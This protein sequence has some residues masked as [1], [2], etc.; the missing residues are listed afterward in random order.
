ML[1]LVVAAIV[2]T[3][4]CG[5]GRSMTA[6]TRREMSRLYIVMAADQL[7]PAAAFEFLTQH[8]SLC[9]SAIE[10]MNI[11]SRSREAVKASLPLLP[12]ECSHSL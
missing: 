8:I 2:M 1:R 12:Y 4:S 11:S 3:G 7:T 6:T 5:S 9:S 10:E